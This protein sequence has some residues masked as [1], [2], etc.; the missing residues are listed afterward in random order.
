MYRCS[1]VPRC[2]VSPLGRSQRGRA[3]TWAADES[4]NNAIP[5]CNSLIIIL[6]ARS[7]DILGTRLCW[8]PLFTKRTGNLQDDLTPSF[9]LQNACRLGQSDGWAMHPPRFNLRNLKF[10]SFSSLTSLFNR[11]MSSSSSWGGGSCLAGVPAMY[12]VV[13]L[14]NSSSN[15][16]DFCDERTVSS[17]LALFGIWIIIHR[18]NPRFR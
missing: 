8:L 10:S 1:T 4:D 5:C 16:T 6:L 18:F 14:R 13:V 15:A 12:L 7:P 2:K 17:A 3:H 9:I 11:I